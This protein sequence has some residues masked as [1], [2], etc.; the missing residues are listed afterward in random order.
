VAVIMVTNLASGLR[1]SGWSDPKSGWLSPVERR[2][3]DALRVR[4]AALPDRERPVVFVI[5]QAGASPAAWGFVKLSG[6][7]SRYGLPPGEIDRGFVYLGSVRNYLAGRPTLRH[8]ATYDKL[9][10]AL[11]QDAAAGVQSARARPLIV[12]AAIFNS[13]GS[14]AALL[15]GR[16]PGWLRSRSADVWTVSDG[17]VL[18]ASG[19]AP[20]R[21]ARAV[22]PAPAP[23]HLARVAAGL[24]ILVLPGFLVLGYFV[25]GGKLAEVLGMAPALA[26]AITALAGIG[27]LAVAR[28]PFSGRLAWTTVALA[29]LAAA[30][31]ALFGRGRLRRRLA[32]G[33]A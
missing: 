9:S 30:V 18:A 7:T 22:T 16:D 23:S 26:M 12:V 8:S 33:A 3:L 2:D 4:L 13:S 5:D 25:P 27:V 19:P 20:P 28:A 24:A 21:A 31:A 6:N 29:A 10:R 15:R 14:N 17:R 1:A 32:G 11:L